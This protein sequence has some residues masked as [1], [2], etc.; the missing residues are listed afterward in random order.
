MV[1]AGREK[2]GLSID[3]VAAQ[4]NIP[5]DK[6][7]AVE[8]DRYDKLASEVFAQGYLRRYGK[9]VGVD[10][11]V[12][13]ARFNE[14]MTRDRRANEEAAQRE[15]PSSVPN[16]SRWLVPGLIFLV[17]VAVLAFIFVR[18]ASDDAAGPVTANRQQPVEQ[19]EAPDGAE[20]T[21]SPA[22]AE[23]RNTPELGE[24]SEP[25]PSQQPAAGEQSPPGESP[26]VT[27]AAVTSE[28]ATEQNVAATEQTREAAPASTA[29]EPEPAA[30]AGEDVL[31]FVFSEDCWVEVTDATGTVIHAELANAGESLV[32]EGQGPFSLMLGNARAVG[33]SYNG[34]TVTVNPRP[35]ART[36]KMRVG[37]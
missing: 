20:T 37:E 31:S 6:L 21:T 1:K 2:A 33:L 28:K 36:L 17:A 3:D 22:V 7:R 16:L 23:T 35:G 25:P 11:N 14:F 34:E 10:D 13:V 32:V 29:A 9:L 19:A 5:A 18:T 30:P 15:R 4:L 8:E 24:S 12:L 26:A 27:E